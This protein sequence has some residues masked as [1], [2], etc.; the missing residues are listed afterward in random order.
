M[1]KQSDLTLLPKV[2]QKYPEIQVVYL[3]G[4]AVTGKLHEESDLDLAAFIEGEVPSDMK[5]NL[6]S[7]LARLGFC[8]V[9]LVFMNT[10]DIVLKYEAVRQNRVVY[11]RPDFDRGT[12][13]SN[14][15]RQYLDF[16]PH[17]AVQREAYKK[18]IM[19]G[20]PGSHTQKVE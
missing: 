19:N 8:D 10:D 2:F 4:S 9:D 15:V 17:L 3:F 11:Q 14:I 1:K 5:L 18:R 12:N 16:Y 20:A 7:E 13:Y 6:L